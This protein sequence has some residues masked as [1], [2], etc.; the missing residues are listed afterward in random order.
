M[1]LK[2]RALAM[3]EKNMGKLKVAS[4]VKVENEDDL[5]LAYSPGVAYPCL[6]IEKNNNDIYKYTN[7]SN[8]VAIV[9]NGSAVLGLGNIGASASMPVM[10][11]KSV[12]FKEFGAIDGFPI[13]LDTEDPEEIIK[14]VKMMEPTFGG[15]NLEDIKA[16]ECFLIEDR[17]KKEMDIPVFHDDQHGTAIIVLGALI[18]SLKIVNKKMKDLRV[19]ISGA[20]AAGISLAK[21]IM[22]K[23]VQDVVLINSKGAIYDGRD[24]MNNA[25][26]QIAKITN[27]KHKKGQLGDVINGADVFLGVSVADIMTEEMVKAMADDPI[28]FPM[29]NPDPEIDPKLAFK[30]G[31]KIVGTGRSD[32]PNQINNVLAFPGVFRGALD[33]RAREINM[34]MKIAAAEALANL[35]SDDELKPDY[36]IPKPFDKRVGSHVAAAVAET[37]VKTGVARRRI[38]YKEEFENATKLL[39]R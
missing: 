30:A 21:I 25:Q 16:P 22:E 36:V 13:C 2:K 17:L 31:A 37:A 11:G 27:L 20:G 33:V 12:L 6:E 10:E 3:H 38:S 5:T 26:K 35:V 39:A 19:V 15:I 24:N 4:K 28:V 18:N 32:Y 23:G 34:E 1:D 8:F 7:K 14:T 9:S 29:A